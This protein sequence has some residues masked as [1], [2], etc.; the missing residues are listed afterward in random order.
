[1]NVLI[2]SDLIANSGVGQYMVQLGGE[3]SENPFNRVVLASPHIERN[4]IPETVELIKLPETNHILRYLRQ[5][6]RI[7]KKYNINIVHC[8]H[9]K[10]VFIMK[11][12]QFIYGK[13]ATVWTCHTIPYPNN[14]IKKM[15]GYYGHKAIAISTEAQIWMHNELHINYERIDKITNGVDDSLLVIPS[16]EKHK[17]KEEF[18]I[19]HYNE[20]IK[21]TDTKVIV[22]HGRLH[23]VKG[24]DLLLKA[25]AQ[26]DKKKRQNVKLVLS[27]DT[28]DPYYNVLASLITEYHLEEFVYFTGWITSKDILSIADLMVQPS[29]REGFLLAALEAFFMKVPVIRSKVGGYEDMKNLCIGVPAGDASAIHKEIDCW[30]TNPNSYQNMVEKAYLFAKQ[31]GTVKVM[32]SKTIETYKKA[33]KI[34]QS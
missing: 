5:L 13:I 26:L 30:L 21:G 3:I 1:M 24:L 27:G 17:L 6:H 8:N 7:V 20:Y 32:A 18:F 25:F 19:K 23:P 34:C 2:L 4:D 29:H 12:Y 15:L 14:W 16:I 22:A 11:L 31:E 28:K 10:Q 9:R 33:I